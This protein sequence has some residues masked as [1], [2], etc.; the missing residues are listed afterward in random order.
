MTDYKRNWDHE[1]G[2]T[3][4]KE[5]EVELQYLIDYRDRMMSGGL[6]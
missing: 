2:K 5:L 4:L 6:G 1:I 3:Y